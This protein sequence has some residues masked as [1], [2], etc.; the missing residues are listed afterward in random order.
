MTTSELD[1]FGFCP[2]AHRLD[3]Q[4]G[5]RSADG[6]GTPG[7]A[8]VRG[9]DLAERQWDT[10]AAARG[11]MAH[12]RHA[13]RTTRPTGAWGARVAMAYLMLALA[14][15]AILKFGFGESSPADGVLLWAFPGADLPREAL[16]LK[17]S[18][19]LFGALAV[20]CFVVVRRSGTGLQR[21]GPIVYADDGQSGT[22][23]RADLDISGRPDYVVR[24][25]PWFFKE[26]R[27]VE[28]K[29]GRPPSPAPLDADP[30]PGHVLELEGQGLLIEGHVGRY[31]RRGY[32][33]YQDGGKDVIHPVRL[34]ARA[35]AQALAV[36]QAIRS[37]DTAA[38]LPVDARCNGCKHRSVCPLLQAPALLRP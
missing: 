21:L 25:G 34:G 3:L 17:V 29:S 18:L 31:P 22:F 9:P 12:S 38:S 16:Q 4:E 32:V 33:V 30:Y 14:T 36:V 2:Q 24:N 20:A 1:V 7:G 26:Y 27:P 6:V 15:S 23:Y 11:R 19:A 13:Q 5:R 35:K 37:G 10:P 28:F 8:H